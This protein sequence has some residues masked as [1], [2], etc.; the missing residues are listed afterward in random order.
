MRAA[1]H[2]AAAPRRE[3]MRVSYALGQP[4]E[5]NKNKPERSV[6]GQMLAVL[7]CLGFLAREWNSRHN[8]TSAGGLLGCTA[9]CGLVSAVALVCCSLSRCAGPFP[10]CTHLTVC[11]GWCA[12]GAAQHPSQP[13]RGRSN[14]ASSLA[15]LWHQEEQQSI[16]N[17]RAISNLHAEHTASR[18]VGCS[19]RGRI[20]LLGAGRGN[21]SWDSVSTAAGLWC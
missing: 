12:A 17:L 5:A 6:R 7:S 2:D 20:G 4:K 21:I 8:S 18:E 9:S 10:C 16:S 3:A 19:C 11:V 15:W 1:Q 13:A 14:A